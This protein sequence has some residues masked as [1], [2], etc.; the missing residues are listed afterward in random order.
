[1]A[2][3]SSS[4][5]PQ[6]IHLCFGGY[7]FTMFMFRVKE[8]NLL[9][10][11]CKLYFLKVGIEGLYSYLS[12]RDLLPKEIDVHELAAEP[13]SS[14]ELDLLGT[15]H[16]DI[17]NIILRKLNQPS[18]F[19][20]C[21]HAMANIILKIFGPLTIVAIHIDEPRSN[22]KVR[23]YRARDVKR[24]IADAKLDTL[25][26]NMKTKSEGQFVHSINIF[27]GGIQT[28]AL[29]QP[30]AERFL[31]YHDRTLAAISAKYQPQ[32][33]FFKP[34]RAKPDHYLPV[35][36]TEKRELFPKKYDLTNCK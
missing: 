28:Q 10:L 26:A 4:S 5:S 1:M 9:S 34:K 11:D 8:L 33:R 13:D 19:T 30:T 21:D 29:K 17:H 36:P 27:F 7:G 2:A 25:I 12:R 20:V 3:S 32:P 22:E 35:F 18:S 16:C 24:T 6:I 23:A 14:F 15:F 31:H